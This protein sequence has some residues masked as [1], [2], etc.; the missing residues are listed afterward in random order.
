MSK[1]KKEDL[2]I[3]EENK[4]DFKMSVIERKNLTNEFTIHSIEVHQKSL[5]K[6]KKEIDATVSLAKSMVGNIE[7]NHK[8][9]LDSLTPEKIAT[10]WLWQENSN[11]IKEGEPVQQEVDAQIAKNEEYMETIY[12][13]F[14][15]VKSEEVTGDNNGKIKRE[16]KEG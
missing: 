13:A 3:K 12:D 6:S 9:L 7:K 4:D 1:L 11:I 14:G 15:F 8:K 2:S 10:V 16:S 5:E